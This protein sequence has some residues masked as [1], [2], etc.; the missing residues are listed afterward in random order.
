MPLNMYHGPCV[1][2]ALCSDAE[3]TNSRDNKPLISMFSNLERL[4]HSVLS[5]EYTDIELKI[6]HFKIFN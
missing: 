6:F 5:T 4:F 1:H 3:I 2:R